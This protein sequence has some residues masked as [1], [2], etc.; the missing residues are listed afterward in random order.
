MF[1]IKMNDKI[2]IQHRGQEGFNLAKVDGT[3][4]SLFSNIVVQH[5]HD[6]CTKETYINSEKNLENSFYISASKKKLAKII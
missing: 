2:F 6:A 4:S 3:Y 1:D 5:F